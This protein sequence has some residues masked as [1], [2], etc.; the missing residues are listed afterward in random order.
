MRDALADTAEEITR[1]GVG[2]TSQTD[3]N[4]LSGLVPKA[5]GVPWRVADLPEEADVLFG[6]DVTCDADTGQHVGASA[7]VIQADGT[8]FASRTQS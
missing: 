4:L 8:M 2:L 1:S 7:A 5:G 6:L 3:L